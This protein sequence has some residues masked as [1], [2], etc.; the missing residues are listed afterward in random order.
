MVEFS[1]V[2]ICRYIP[3]KLGGCRNIFC[4]QAGEPQKL[5]GFN[6]AKIYIALRNRCRIGN[7][8]VYIILDAKSFFRPER[9]LK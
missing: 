7:D 5:G 9:L 6:S 2:L 4:V 1:S 8:A 3:N